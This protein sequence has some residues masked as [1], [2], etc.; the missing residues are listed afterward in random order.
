[1]KIKPFYQLLL[2]AVFVGLSFSLAG[3]AFKT[4]VL[5]SGGG[6]KENNLSAYLLAPANS[7]EFI[8]LD[9]G[10]V[11]SGIERAVNSGN[12][13]DVFVPQESDASKT[14]Y[15][16]RVLI[17]GYL[18]THAHLDHVAGLV[19]ASQASTKKNIYTTATTIDYLKANVFNWEIWPN[20]TDEGAGMN[21]GIF[22]FKTLIFEQEQRIEET[23]MYVK[24]F[25]LSHQNPY[26]STA[27]LIR[28]LDDYVLY[29]GDTGADEL[30]GVNYL[31]EVWK[32]IA[33]IIREDKLKAI[34]LECSYP[35]EQPDSKLYG[36]LNPKWM[37][38]ELTHLAEITDAEKIDETLKG[39]PVIVTG[40]KPSW[41]QGGDNKYLIYKQLLVN[42][43]LGVR[44]I[45]PEQGQL[46]AF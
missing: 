20:F 12:F 17:K 41:E 4:I 8:C 39:L 26:E 27:F 21:L 40:I 16:F 24:P 32:A 6:I 22:D 18:I 1:M 43:D 9:G 35:N 13:Y 15:I 46:I 30:E 45:I 37:I 5:G 19:I 23:N 33:P 29:A 25:R 38:K 34:F 28:Y 42:N 2:I 14:G 3:Q 44:F 31:E 10:T 11:Y 36:H 7:N